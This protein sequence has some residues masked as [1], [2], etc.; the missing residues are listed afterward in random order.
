MT[1]FLFFIN[2][3]LIHVLYKAYRLC[4]SEHFSIFFMF[5]F[6]VSFYFHMSLIMY[7][8]KNIQH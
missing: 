4:G 2:Y 1:Q 5:S 7:F 8:A 6:C 3:P